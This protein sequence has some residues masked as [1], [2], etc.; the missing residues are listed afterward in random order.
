MKVSVKKYAEALALS[1]K[2]DESPDSYKEKIDNFLKLLQKRKK[3][4]LTKRFFPAFKD[5]W[6]KI[7][8]K[9]EVKVTVPHRLEEAEKEELSKLLGSAFGKEVIMNVHVDNGIIGGLKLEAG[10]YV[11]DGSLA[12]NLEMLK[13]Q[14]ISSNI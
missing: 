9:I 7:I 5:E 3:L 1:L 4:K 6:Y 8:K 14:I 10:E 11:I 2:G 12:K 13:A